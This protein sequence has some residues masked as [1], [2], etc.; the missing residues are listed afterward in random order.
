MTDED[1]V[2]TPHECGETPVEPEKWSIWFL[3]GMICNLFANMARSTISFAAGWVN[4]YEELGHAFY[5]HG[6][7]KQQKKVENDVVD[8]FREQLASF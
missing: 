2:P 4:F 6:L 5:A 8:S 1:E 3:P 7:Y